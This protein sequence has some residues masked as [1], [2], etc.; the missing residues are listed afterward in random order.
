MSCRNDPPTH[1][2]P[3]LTGGVLP[4][5]CQPLTRWQAA[6]WFAGGWVWL[7]SMAWAPTASWWRELD[8]AVYHAAQ[9]L[10]QAFPT[11]AKLFAILN[12]HPA[13]NLVMDAAFAA[14]GLPWLWQAQCRAELVRKLALLSY[15]VVAWRITMSLINRWLFTTILQWQ[16]LSPSLIEAPAV[17]LRELLPGQNVKVFAT[18]TFPSDHAM[19]LLFLAL[20]MW[21]FGGT[22]RGPIVGISLFFCVPRLMSGAHWLSDVAIGGLGIAAVAFGC[23]FAAPFAD[24]GVRLF[25]W[26]WRTLLRATSQPAPPNQSHHST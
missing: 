12:L 17:N 26:F 21:R 25:S 18:G 22:L 6:F 5:G 11:L 7:A 1:P 23:W 3:D 16:S 9:G 14:V 4:V 8:W 19:Q 10:L 2:K 24:R 15:Y 13:G 20:V